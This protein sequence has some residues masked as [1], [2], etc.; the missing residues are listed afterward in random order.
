VVLDVRVIT[1]T[2][3]GPDKTILNAPR[4]LA[5]HGYHNLCAFLH[6][7]GDPGMDILRE[8]AESLEAPLVSIPDRGPLDPRV[9]TAL[10][11]LCRREKVAIWH[12]HD[13]KSNLIGLLLRPFWP[14]ALVTT[15]HG[16]VRHTRSTPLYYA[17]DRSCLRF[18]ER[19]VCVSEDLYQTCR[20]LGVSE[21]RCLLIEN[22]IDTDRFSRR[23][24]TEEAKRR[25]GLPPGGFSI[26]SVG[27]LSE[28]K[29]H[30]LLIH[31]V[32]RLI[33]QGHDV[34]LLIV[35]E[36]SQHEKLSSLI[37]EL[38]RQDRIRLCGFQS[39][40]VSMYE[41]M[42]LFVLSSLR[43]GLPNVVLEAMALEVP[44]VSTRIAG[45]PRLIEDGRNGLLIDPG[46]IDGLVAAT[47]RM[48]NDPALRASVQRA[49]RATVEE[50]HGFAR[51]MERFR[52]LYDELLTG[53]SLSITSQKEA[54]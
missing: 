42:D 43:E 12:G 25:L 14:M 50:H 37:A 41:A 10:L 15:V 21:R 4:F 9:L 8:R 29:A 47:E 16:W 17:I 5:P 23:C 44:V 35:G 22:A 2:G 45:I 26:G 51:R 13:Y 36:G 3:G 1:G 11:S 49:A 19:V 40:V 6:P 54:S 20:D 24:G 30:D 46:S 38:G 33:R 31:A 34:S 48:I 18:Y 52:A 39:D 27:R 53:G 32:D 28:E 7:P